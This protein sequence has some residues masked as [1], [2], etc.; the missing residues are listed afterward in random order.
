MRAN[1]LTL[2]PDK[3]EVLLMGLETILGGNCDLVLDG[4][5]LSRKDQVRNVG[6]LL[7]LAL[8]LDKQV[9]AMVMSAF[10]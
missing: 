9:A 10:H 6:V 2:N 3:A 5:V 4:V 7:G 8:L 1:K